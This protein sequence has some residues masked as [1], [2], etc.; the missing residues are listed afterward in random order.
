MLGG[1]IVTPSLVFHL[2]P[3]MSHLAQTHCRNFSIWQ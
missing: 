3:E 1:C 2:K